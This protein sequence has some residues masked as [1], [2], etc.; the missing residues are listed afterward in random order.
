MGF[1]IRH[2]M[3]NDSEF[4]N[5]HL[6]D[7]SLPS[8]CKKGIIA[9]VFHYLSVINLNAKFSYLFLCENFNCKKK[10]TRL[11]LDSLY[12]TIST[13]PTSK[14]HLPLMMNM[15]PLKND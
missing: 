13:D 8:F 15:T 12:V 5:W 2:P 4:C 6:G 1:N 9:F 3:Q 10:L 11:L 7:M 14:P